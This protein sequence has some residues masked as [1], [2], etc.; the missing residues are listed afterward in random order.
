[1]YFPLLG[2]TD[3]SGD[4]GL[5]DGPIHGVAQL[6]DRVRPDMGGHT[7]LGLGQPTEPAEQF[8][9][10]LFLV[11][12]ESCGRQLTTLL[13]FVVGGQQ[14]FGQPRVGAPAREPAPR[15]G[16]RRPYPART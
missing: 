7:G 2:D 9:P 15:R 16:D 11:R 14:R 1:M 3:L 10:G 5:G 13:Q 12:G 6:G 4:V 8:T